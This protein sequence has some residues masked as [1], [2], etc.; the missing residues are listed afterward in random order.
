MKNF[1][2]VPSVCIDLET[3]GKTAGS[4][5]VSI[6]AVKFNFETGIKYKFKINISPESAKSYG[7]HTDQSTLQWWMEQS[8]EARKAWQTDPHE[9]KEAFQ[10]FNDWLGE[11]K[12]KYIWANGVAF[13]MPI[14]AAAY[15]KLD[16][17]QPWTYRQEMDMRTVYNMLGFSNS[18]KL[19]AEGEVYH[20][21]LEDAISQTNSLISLFKNE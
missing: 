4:I 2:E 16:I 13:D 11:C 5:I 21:A 3:L 15:T 8:K 10:Q 7:F 20:D 12:N 18:A 9:C 14:L 17:K 6:G 1:M 19:E